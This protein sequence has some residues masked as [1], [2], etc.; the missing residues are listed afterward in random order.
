VGVKEVTEGVAKVKFPELVAVLYPLYTVIVPVVA[1]V[2]TVTTKE[3]VLPLTLEAVTPLNITILLAKTALNP[4]PV[5]VIVSPKSPG[6]G[7][8]VIIL[9]F[10][11][12]SVALVTVL[13][14]LFTVIL[15]VDAPAGIVT[16]NDEALPAEIVAVTPLNLTVLFPKVGSKPVPVIVTVLPIM[17]LVGLN[18]LI[19]GLFKVK[20]PELTPVPL[21][22]DT[23]MVPEVAPDGTVIVN[24]VEL[25]AVTVA[26]VPLI[27]TVLL[28]EVELNPVPI[29]V[30]D[31]PMFPDVGV[32]DDI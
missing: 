1:P 31:V 12:K 3:V 10:T 16:V 29:I 14:P 28:P 26:V 22:F 9:G 27:S 5:M 8:N 25:P 32:K 20:V 30:T 6:V 21:P 2:G 18:E 11:V 17:A 24:D 13:E 23:D 4:V 7:L 19:V 15:P